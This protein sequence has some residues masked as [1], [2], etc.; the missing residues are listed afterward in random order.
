MQLTEREACQRER[1]SAM[2]KRMMVAIGAMVLA[3]ATGAPVAAND[4]PSEADAGLERA[5][6][7][8]TAHFPI[9]NPES[10]AVQKVREA[11]SWSWGETQP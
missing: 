2:R 8:S 10:P 5:N 3:L 4:P 9:E 11:A 1:R 7:E 6:Q